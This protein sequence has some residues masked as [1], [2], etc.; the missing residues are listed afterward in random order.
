M[1]NAGGLEHLY[2]SVQRLRDRVDSLEHENASLRDALEDSG[3]LNFGPAFWASVHRRRFAAA[4]RRDPSFSEVIF[5]DLLLDKSLASAIADYEDSSA[6][7]AARAPRQDAAPHAA[8]ADKD[9]P[10][11]SA[12]AVTAASAGDRPPPGLDLEVDGT[13]PVEQRLATSQSNP[14]SLLPGEANMTI[15]IFGG[16]DDNK[17]LN[18][19][20][21]FNP[22]TNAWE[23]LAS[24][25]QARSAAAAAL[26]QDRVY[27]CGGNHCGQTLNNVERYDF[28]TGTWETVPNMLKSRSAAA[29][30]E[31]LGKL[32]LCGGWSGK[33]AMATVER[34]DPQKNQW[35]NVAPMAHRREWPVVTA[36]AGQLYLC[37]GQDGSEDVS[38]VECFDPT[39]GVWETL[40]MK[41]QCRRN[42]AIA[43]VNSQL[44]LCGGH[45]EDGRHVLNTVERFNPVT[46][47]WEALAPMQTHRRNSMA[48]VL[49]GRIYVCGGRGSRGHHNH[50]GGH[51]LRTAERFDPT[52]GTWEPIPP[53]ASRRYRSAAIVWQN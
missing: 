11:E 45:G 2:L 13:K 41:V 50:G 34:F 5:S 42:A 36:D 28:K 12:A 8:D 23:P 32:Y 49:A 7:L 1:T 33:Q 4:R 37:G 26:V 46:A 3:V 9:A 38:A 52:T 27:V 22:A 35:E 43:V 18:S 25:K 31:L 53:M 51:A 14:S 16:N 6:V 48:M 40:A 39:T 47:M 10:A 44:Y 15:Y 21:R 30:A 17:T 29:A 24:M 20:E 19:C